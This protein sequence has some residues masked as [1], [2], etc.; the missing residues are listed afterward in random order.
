MQVFGYAPVSKPFDFIWIDV[1]MRQRILLLD[2]DRD[3]LELYREFLEHLPS[4]PEVLTADGGAKAI[5]ML[6]SAPYNLLVSDLNM[7][8]M[9]GLQVLSIVRQRFPQLRTV[10][11]TSVLDEQFRSRAYGLGV[12]LFWHKPGSEEESRQFLECI[13]SLLGRESQPG[14]RGVQS[15][16][17]M[18]IIQM[19]CLSKNSAV[20]KIANGPLNGRIWIHEGEVVDAETDPFTGE[21]AFR[22]IFAWK[23]GCFESLPGEPTRVRT[24]FESYHQLL[25]GTAQAHDESHSREGKFLHNSPALAS[26]L[27]EFPGVEFV[28]V[29]GGPDE[30]PLH[31]GAVEKAQPTANWS[32]QMFQQF[33]ALGEKLGAGPLQE[34]AA[35]G[36]RGHISLASHHDLDLCVGWKREVDPDEIHKSTRK[37]IALW[38][39]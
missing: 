15:K 36:T 32:R 25:L 38:E 22:R 28:L 9:D 7:P 20:L 16:S 18:D 1:T 33:R 30:K 34:M 12:D 17:L 14:F 13:E 29:L 4:K 23:E 6:E 21:E 10:V 3:V 2:D 24:I 11:L 31:F 26:P 27:A 37:V 35:H 8:R 39:S 19:E 5:S